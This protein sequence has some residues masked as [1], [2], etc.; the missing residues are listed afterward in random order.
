MPKQKP[1]WTCPKCGNRFVTRNMWHSCSDHPLA[2][3][4]AGKDELVRRLYDGFASLVRECGPFTVVSQKTRICFM[5]RVRFAG[6]TTRK[7]WLDAG[8]Y[9]H[10][11]VEHP[12]FRRVER[13]TAHAY[14]HQLRLASPADL[15]AARQELMPVLREA[16]AVGCQ[17]DEPPWKRTLDELFDL[18]VV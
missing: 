10:R 14:G 9:L 8:L 4:F 1:L 16:Y 17:K 3:H 12:L 5:V 13:Y 18:D 2:G 15:E 7:H 6:V 11:R